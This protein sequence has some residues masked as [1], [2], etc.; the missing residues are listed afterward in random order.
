MRELLAQN[1]IRVPELYAESCD[2]GWLLVE[3]LGDT[4]AQ[5]LEH[6]PQ[7][8]P[9]LYQRAV[10]DLARAQRLLASLPE[11][12]IVLQRAFDV[13]LL[14]WELDHFWEWALEAR[15]IVLDEGQR[16]LFHRSR[17]TTWRPRSPLGHA[18]SCTATTR[19]AI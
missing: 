16:A 4:L 9:A 13:D 15:G 7:D 17:G 2:D 6:S 1:A 5:H 8:R 11:H 18:A 19:A 10:R 12:S 14:R 3:D